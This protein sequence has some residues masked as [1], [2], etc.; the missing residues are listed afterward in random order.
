MS[1]ASILAADTD[2]TPFHS[3]PVLAAIEAHSEAWSVFQVAPCGEPAT[4][5]EDAADGALYTLLGTACAT[6]AGMLCLVRHLRW[7]LT[8][9]ASNAS[10]HGDAWAVAQAREADLSLCLGVER[11]ERLP[12]AL[13]SGRLIGPVIDLRPVAVSTPVRFARGLSRLGDV[14]AALVLIVGGCGLT[15]LASLL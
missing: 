3:D 8:E 4:R 10:R 6:R 14:V 9:E 1:H 11:V 15:G 2:R 12:I 5:A 7:F 13:P